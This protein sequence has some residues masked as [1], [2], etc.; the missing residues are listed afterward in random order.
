MEETES[1]DDAY[2]CGDIEDRDLEIDQSN[3][4]AAIFIERLKASNIPSSLVQ[5]II[6]DTKEL[7]GNFV[8]DVE[9]QISDIL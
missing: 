5:T 7:I 4:P 9:K 6:C 3:D 8:D 2:S 1:G